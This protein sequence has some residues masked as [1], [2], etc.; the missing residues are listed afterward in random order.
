[1]D[2]M[3]KRISFFALVVLAATRQTQACACAPATFDSALTNNDGLL[4]RATVIREVTVPSQPTRSDVAMATNKMRRYIVQIARVVKGCTV[5]NMERIMVTS[6]G[7]PM[8]G[9][10]LAINSEYVLSSTA[11]QP[12]DAASRAMLGNRSKVTRNVF[13]SS[14]G[15]SRIWNAVSE[16][17][18]ITMRDF[19]NQCNTQ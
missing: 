3:I 6:I 8:C 4:F 1:M 10:T 19:S 12:L 2:N 17:D 16:S 9:T 7:D 18:R 15:F 14:C 11:S 5:K 13:I